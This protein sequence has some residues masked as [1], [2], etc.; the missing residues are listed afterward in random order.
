MDG[1]S[2]A[3]AVVSLAIQLVTTVKE[4][5]AFLS[6]VSNAPRELIRLTSLL[7]QL[8]HV[9]DHVKYLLEHQHESLGETGATFVIETALENC[10]V[11][12]ELLVKVVERVKDGFNGPGA[13]QCDP[14]WFFATALGSLRFVGRRDEIQKIERDLQT[15]TMGL[16]MGMSANLTQLQ[17]VFPI[18]AIE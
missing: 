18:S 11:Q 17:Y 6:N 8:H 12:V 14:K 7:N 2:G 10:R 1:I 4:I 16:Q 15:A 5:H 3:F 13:H 9:L